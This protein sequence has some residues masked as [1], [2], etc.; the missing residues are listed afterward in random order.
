MNQI[1]PGGSLE[2]SQ[3]GSYEWTDPNTGQKHLIPK[4]TSTQ[5]LSDKGQL[6]YD[7]NADA[8][9]NLANLAKDQSA[10]IGSLLGTP[11]DLSNESVE[12]RLMELG[13]SRL[14]PALERR[15]ESLRT[16]LSNQGIKLGSE[17]YDR[18]MEGAYQGENDAYNELLLKG[19]GQSIQEALASRNQ[20]INEISAL[21]SGSQVSLPNFNVNQPSP[22]PTTDYAGLVNQN[23][24]QRLGIW[25]Q[26][27]AQKQATLGG[28]FGLAAGG[29]SGGYF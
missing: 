9:I 23:Y 8:Q 26:Q 24:N 21:M 27:Q 3:S 1:T 5:K 14:D 13:R 2:Y 28:L 4:F 11:I 16:S 17:A 22:I 10:R 29:L 19:R 12:S 25:Q 15:R 20:P 7:A 18:A 6:A